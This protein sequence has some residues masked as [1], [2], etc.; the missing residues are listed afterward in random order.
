MTDRELEQKLAAALSHA[1]P[2]DPEDV[3]S[4][5]EPRKGTVIPMMNQK[6]TFRPGRLIAACLA[7]ALICGFSLNW[8]QT[9]AVTSVISL[10]VNPSIELEINRR[11]RVI[12]CRPLN[13]DAE[14]VLAD[15]NGGADLEGAKLSVAVNAVTGA[16]VRAGYL[17]SISSAILISVEDRDQTRAARLQQEL[18]SVVDVVLQGISSDAAVLSQTVTKDTRLEQ[19][20]RENNVSTGKAYLIRRAMELNGT[21]TFDGLAALT[22][23][24][25]RD[26]IEAGAPGMPVGCDAAVDAVLRYA[27]LDMSQII[28]WEV[29]AELDEAPACYE[30]DLRVAGGEGHYV[31]DAYTGEVHGSTNY[32]VMPIVPPDPKPSTPP[33]DD[34]TPSPSLSAPIDRDQALDIALAHAGLTREEITDLEVELEEL[35]YALEF[36]CGGYEY[37]YTV[38]C[39][40]GAILSHEK[41][42]HHGDHHH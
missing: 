32:A 27:G 8:Q 40:G 4:R 24:E 10:D 17:D 41:E 2:N 1:A 6:K 16:L 11:E 34:P 36:V 18:A 13:T 20:A 28:R 42:H 22:V 35:E 29:D 5:C 39:S 15:M 38:H 19:Q 30:V 7:L 31:V 3:L 21:L 23:E 25:L 33:A 26:L 12:S 14:Q 9:R 37:E